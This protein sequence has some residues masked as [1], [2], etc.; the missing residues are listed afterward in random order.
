[1]LKFARYSSSLAKVWIKYDGGQ[2]IEVSTAGCDDISDLT[3]AIKLKLPFPDYYSSRITLHPSW[4]APAFPPNLSIADLHKSAES[5]AG[6]VLLFV[7]APKSKAAIIMSSNI[8]DA[9]KLLILQDLHQ[10]ESNERLFKTEI[11]LREH[12]I[13]FQKERNAVLLK[14]KEQETFYKLYYQQLAAIR[15]LIKLYEN[16]FKEIIFYNN[17]LSRNDKWRAFLQGSDKNFRPFE[18]AGFT[19][20]EVCRHVDSISNCNSAYIESID[21]VLGLIVTANG[22]LSETQME[23]IKIL[24]GESS[25]RHIIRFE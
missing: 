15:G 11:A 17:N 10:I 1:M 14:E 4:T 8:A 20:D 16:N 18:K 24:V 2:I 6:D 12:E 19:V 7:K 13:K 5:N 25:W 3:E 21:A 22:T 23:I 9:D